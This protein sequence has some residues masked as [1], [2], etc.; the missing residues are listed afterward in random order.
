[1]CEDNAAGLL[2][3]G[4][5]GGGGGEGPSEWYGRWNAVDDV[6]RIAGGPCPILCRRRW[7]REWME[8]KDVRRMTTTTVAGTTADGEQ[9]WPKAMGSDAV[10]IGFRTRFWRALDG[11]LP[12]VFHTF[13][14]GTSAGTIGNRN[15]VAADRIMLTTTNT[16]QLRVHHRHVHHRRVVR[17]F[18][19]LLN[20]TT[21]SF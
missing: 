16:K 11:R 15:K 6:D 17:H 8:N 10:S 13:P 14:P 7:T 9:W 3:T 2:S 12:W 20:P 4:R 5:G 18:L 21:R 1:M 19:S